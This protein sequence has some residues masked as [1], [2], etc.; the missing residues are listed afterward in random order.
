M[1]NE[2][3][4]T[5]LTEIVNSEWIR[6]VFQ[7]YSHEFVNATRFCLKQS[8]VGKGTSTWAQ[9]RP[10]SDLGTVGDGGTSVDT[11]FN[12]TEATDLSTNLQLDL[13]ESTIA[14]SEYGVRR[15]ITDTA[16]EDVIDGFAMVQWIVRDAARILMTALEDDV[17]G[18]FGS[19]TNTTGSTGVN[20]TVANVNAAIAALRNRGIR[21]PGGLVGVLSDTQ[22]GDFT[23]ALEATGTSWA[24]Y[25]ATADRLMAANRNA[26][27]GLT[28]GRVLSYKN[29]DFYQ[30]GLVDTA[31]TGADDVGAIFTPAMG[32]EGFEALGLAESRPFT[33]ETE[34]NASLRSTEVICTMRAGVGI[35]LQDCIQ[36][37]VTDA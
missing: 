36:A 18:L 4:T 13:A 34:R 8:L 19:A 9:P 3:T 14:T 22:M 23:D 2:T 31:N 25:P 32:N 27:N 35:L 10:V 15:E 20:I 24:V 30:S 21:A 11:E 17:I 26:D 5:T 12:A 28:D 29:V 33:S 1:A 7:D 16:L 6:P 37:L